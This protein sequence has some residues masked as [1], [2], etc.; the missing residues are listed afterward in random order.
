MRISLSKKSDVPLHRQ[1]SEQIVFQI[2]TG[3]L[4]A[5]TEMPSVRT[6][7]RT[8]GVH[9]NTVSKAYQDLVARGWLKRQQGT[10]LRVKGAKA[11]TS[12]RAKIGLDELINQTIQR[13]QEMGYS[14]QALRTQV[15]ERLLAQPPDHILLIEGEAEL[16][17]ILRAEL[18]SALGRPVE[19]CTPEQLAAEPD[20]AMGAQ[21]V[22]PDYALEL[23]A[24]HVPHNR[25]GIS[26]RFSKAD[27]HL[28]LIRELREPSVVA[29]VSVSRTLLRTA[30]GL[31][32]PVVGRRHAYREVL[33]PAKGGADLRG[34]D[35]AFCDSLSLSKVRCNRKIAYRLLAGECVEG[36]RFT[37]AGGAGPAGGHD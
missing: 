18:E 32:A 12:Q 35:I 13:A 19:T 8:L 33:L 31:L 26:L 15:W 30:S 2:T 27:E 7:A 20:L 4:N 10:R 6:L 1:L 36:I 14:L 16:R 23:L 3:S 21:V 37:L 17:E 25:P 5:A 11:A 24:S 22:A 34:V 9:H 29:V 28:A